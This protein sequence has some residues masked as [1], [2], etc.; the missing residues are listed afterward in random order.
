M[1][2]QNGEDSQDFLPAQ[3]MDV[4]FTEP[5]P[6]VFYTG[7]YQ[8]LFVLGRVH[9]E[10]IG[11]CVI[12]L[13]EQGLT[14]DNLGA[15]LWQEFRTSIMNRF[16][17]AG[18]PVPNTLTGTGL[19][20]DAVSWP[21]WQYSRSVLSAAPFISV[22]IC[23]RDRP[24]SLESCLNS[25]GQQDYP[26][27]ELVVVDNAPTSDAAR[28]VVGTW[29][30]DSAVQYVL[31]PRPG[32]SWARNAGVSVSSGDIIAFLDD[33]EEPD[34]N[35]LTG[36]ACGFAR[37]N[38]I[39]CVSGMVLPAR[40]ETQA[41]E[42]FEQLGGFCKDRGF[43]S[44]IFSSR[45]PQSP[46][47]PLP[48]FG[49]G[50]NMAFRREALARIGGFDVA[51]GAGT[52]TF[53]G[54]DT[55]ALTLTLLAGYCIAYEPAAM[56]RHHHRE[57][58]DGLLGQMRGYSIGLTAFYSALLRHR[59]GVLPGLLRLLPASVGY[60]R[61]SN[62][63]AESPPPSFLNSLAQRRTWMLKGPAA[64]VRSLRKQAHAATQQPSAW[65]G[66]AANLH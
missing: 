49:V 35:W 11:A 61:Q 53:A 42:L 20:V 58:L 46:L 36:L 40:L 26:R 41:Q 19:E 32:L 7:Q 47:Y 59:P 8:R 48:P 9:T 54:E 34:R 22:V 64:Y 12:Y 10:P 21:S 38:D 56:T 51:L 15:L 25:L 45:G 4:E 50:A 2:K 27:F 43:T 3:M 6:T 44:D 57:D 5:L 18:L 29:C 39:G 33:D 28:K 17:A 30:G 62:L 24:S 66:M 23:T 52:P 37:Q 14:P 16:A 60:L 55:L 13:G 65:R 63:T 31:E 1:G